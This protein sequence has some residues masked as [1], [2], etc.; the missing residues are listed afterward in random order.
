MN[1]LEAVAISREKG[2]KIQREGWDNLHIIVNQGNFT[3][4]DWEG[5]NPTITSGDILADDWKIKT[6][7]I[8]VGVIPIG[9]KFTTNVGVEYTKA[10]FKGNNYLYGVRTDTWEIVTFAANHEVNIIDV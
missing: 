4:D 3:L 7:K 6:K 2:F 1:F 5:E 8:T 9:W 10:F